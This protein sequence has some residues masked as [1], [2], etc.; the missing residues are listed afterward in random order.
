M[1]LR[2]LS[3][4]RSL[5][6]AALQRVA[7]ARKWLSMRANQGRPD[8]CENEPGCLVCHATGNHYFDLMDIYDPHSP[9]VGAEVRYIAYAHRHGQTKAGLVMQRLARGI[10]ARRSLE[11]MKRN[12]GSE[13]KL[14][15]VEAVR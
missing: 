5:D 4:M 6:D 1:R 11:A 3:W 12:E 14:S 7:D 2:L 10:L 8:Y 9:V 15:R 13:Q